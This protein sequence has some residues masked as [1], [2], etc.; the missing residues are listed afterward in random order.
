MTE[1]PSP[2]ASEVS[3]IEVAARRAEIVNSVLTDGLKSAEVLQQEGRSYFGSFD[4]GPREFISFRLM[5]PHKAFPEFSSTLR[6]ALYLRGISVLPVMAERQG[7]FTPANDHVDRA[8]DFS[9]G[10]WSGE[11][12]KVVRQVLEP[13]ISS[14]FLI[15]VNETMGNLIEKS[16]R[17]IFSSEKERLRA[18]EH[19]GRLQISRMPSDRF[20]YL[21]FPQSV[22]NEY[23]GRQTH[24]NENSQVRLVKRKI[25]R[26]LFEKKLVL[27]IPD[28]E[29]AL[30]KILEERGEPIWVH[31]VRLPTEDDLL[32][33]RTS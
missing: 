17:F 16:R 10:T 12:K 27:T 21:V 24:L 31:G 5:L 3:S 9:S 32:H 1:R 15:V 2:V 14:S 23:Q 20:S 19:L 30:L 26:T 25:K 8:Y 11:E 4:F 6:D 7:R 29:G 33:P 18:L 13:R 28:Y 22:W